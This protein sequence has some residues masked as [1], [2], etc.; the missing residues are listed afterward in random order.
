MKNRSNVDTSTKI[1]TIT[2]RF[3]DGI[4]YNDSPDRSL[5]SPTFTFTRKF[6]RTFCKLEK[7][8][9]IRLD[10]RFQKRVLVT[11]SLTSTIIFYIFKINTSAV[12][13]FAFISP[14][15]FRHEGQSHSSDGIHHSSCCSTDKNII[16]PPRLNIHDKTTVI[17]INMM[18]VTWTM[19]TP[20]HPRIPPPE[21]GLVTVRCFYLLHLCVTPACVS[22]YLSHVC[23]GPLPS[24]HDG[25]LRK[26]SPWVCEEGEPDADCRS[27]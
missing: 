18:W 27:T 14:P 21:S 6:K 16:S 25:A 1:G 8:H 20:H 7:V 12:L 24:K 22:K 3:L 17:W 13:P 10:T 26:V 4:E 9:Q 15:H 5:F 23:R 2:L 11:N 19:T